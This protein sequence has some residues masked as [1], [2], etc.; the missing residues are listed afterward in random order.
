M[1]SLKGK[2]LRRYVISADKVAEEVLKLKLK[3]ESLDKAYTLTIKSKE[4]L[5]KSLRQEAALL[6]DEIRML[7]ERSVNQGVGLNAGRYGEY[8]KSFLSGVSTL[9]A[10]I[11]NDVYAKVNAD[12]VEIQFLKTY[13]DNLTYSKRIWNSSKLFERDI[14]NVVAEGLAR[15]RDVVNIAR[16]IEV[17][18]RKDKVTLAKRYAN[19]DQSPIR[20]G[21]TVEEWQARVKKFKRR[22][23]TNVE[24]N[25]L[26]IVRSMTQG[27]IQDSNIA[28]ASYSPSV[29]A[30]KWNL[31]PIHIIYSIC[32]DIVAGNPWT[33]EMFP[34]STP[35]H[36]N[37][38]SF[39]TYIEKPI[40]EF[41]K[42]LKKWVNNPGGQSTQYL[43]EWKANYYDPIDKG[44]PRENYFNLLVD[45]ANAS[46]VQQNL[47]R[48]AA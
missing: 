1:L 2:T 44:L 11:L 43:D 4:A 9:D 32:E 47:K 16:D 31:S 21:E 6:R 40:A 27:A 37:C 45:R 29:V 30:F 26:R 28:C 35:P 34:Y 13:G 3:S 39:V 15:N 42:D 46:A 18:V 22:I 33:Y 36:P 48:R 23:S 25:S 10:G 8:N 41:T 5:E 38:N 12:L 19:I 14:R 17:Y 24:Y 20:P 7:T